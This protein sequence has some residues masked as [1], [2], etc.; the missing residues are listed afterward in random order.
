[1]NGWKRILYLRS[2]N[3]LNLSSLNSF[4]MFHTEIVYVVGAILGPDLQ[5]A[6]FWLCAMVASM[7]L[8]VCICTFLNMVFLTVNRYVFIC[9]NKLYSKI[10]SRYTTLAMCIACWLLAVLAEAPNFFGWGGH[11]FDP[12]SHQCIW[13]RTADSSY[14]LFVALGLITTPLLFLAGSNVA[15]LRQVWIT[16]RPGSEK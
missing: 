1:M 14:T 4:Y 16:K 9:H 10:Y 15:I 6:S 11:F 7:C 5:H 2:R 12:K 3:L 8:T 13:D